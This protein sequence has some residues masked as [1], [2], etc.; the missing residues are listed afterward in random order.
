MQRT[1]VRCKTDPL[2]GL[3]RAMP[4]LGTTSLERL[5]T[6]HADL[7][8]VLAKAI[9]DGPDFTVLCGHRDREAQ[10]RAVAEGKSKAPWPKS[11]HNTSPSVAVDIAPWPIDWDDW[12]RFRVLAGYVLGVAAAMDIKLRW[13][14][15]WDR[16]YAETDERF[17]DL[18]HF[19]L[20]EGSDV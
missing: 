2:S 13:G 15:D 8:R 4:T 18:P 19:E 3:M 1:M 5:R 20:M 6:C 16:D 14:G 10:D 11:R 17:R 7:R 9:E 12:N